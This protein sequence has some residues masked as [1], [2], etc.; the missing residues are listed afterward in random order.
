M[1]P[2][3]GVDYNS[4]Y[5]IVNSVVSYPPHY[6]WKGVEWENLYLYAIS[7]TGLLSNH[8]YREVG[9]NGGELT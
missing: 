5:L 7:K 2:Y 4:P 3:A 6:K 9:W 1:G 8:K